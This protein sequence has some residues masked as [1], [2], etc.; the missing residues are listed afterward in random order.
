MAELIMANSTFPSD[1]PSTLLLPHPSYSHYILHLT[2]YT[3]RTH[4][5][6]LL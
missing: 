6:S 2:S 4:L 3:P 5:I 1:V